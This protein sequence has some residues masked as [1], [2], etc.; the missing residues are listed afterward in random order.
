MLANEFLTEID[1]NIITADIHAMLRAN[2]IAVSA[3]FKETGTID[4]NVTTG[5]ISDSAGLSSTSMSVTFGGYGG[6]ADRGFRKADEQ[7][8]GSLLPETEMVWYADQTQIATVDLIDRF[9]YN[10]EEYQVLR[11]KQDTIRSHWRIEVKRSG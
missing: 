8:F 1:R 9:K 7:K 11:M 2:Q 3:I 6:P 4:Y 5:V 10:S